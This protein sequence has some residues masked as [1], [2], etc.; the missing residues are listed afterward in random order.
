MYTRF[1]VAVRRLGEKYFLLTSLLTR[2]I[3]SWSVIEI[4]KKGDGGAVET[5]YRFAD[6]ASKL[7]LPSPSSKPSY[8]D[9]TEGDCHKKSFKCVDYIFTLFRLLYDFSL[10]EISLTSIN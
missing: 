10:L 2:S 9:L 4:L 6:R 3:M 5:L 1:P 8:L 7:K